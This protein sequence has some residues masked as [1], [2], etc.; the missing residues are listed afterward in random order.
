MPR[1]SIKPKHVVNG[2]VRVDVYG[3]IARAVEEGL[4]YGITRL[5]K[6]H[7]GPMSEDEVREQIHHLYDAVMNDLCEV[8]RFDDE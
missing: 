2:V 1:P 8:L 7:D 6:H 5:F 4:R 3:V